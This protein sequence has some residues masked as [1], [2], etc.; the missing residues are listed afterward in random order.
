MD[1]AIGHL[2][3]KAVFSCLSLDFKLVIMVMIMIMMM[4]HYLREHLVSHLL[5]DS[6]CHL[7]FDFALVTC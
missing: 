6:T 2:N 5:A 1:L 4:C 7:G 3:F